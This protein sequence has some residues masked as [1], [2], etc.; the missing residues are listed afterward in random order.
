MSTCSLPRCCTEADAFIRLGTLHH[1]KSQHLIPLTRA[2]HYD[3][4]GR[5][6]IEKLKA[7]NS[8]YAEEVTSKE[9]QLK[10]ERG[11]WYE[12]NL[13]DRIIVDTWGSL[14]LGQE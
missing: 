5:R 7:P 6:V 13:G 11:E 4:I 8:H 10:I 3:Q 2:R 14:L 9:R 12:E 1:P